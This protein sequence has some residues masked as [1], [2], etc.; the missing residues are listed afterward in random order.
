MRRWIAA[1]VALTGILLTWSVARAGSPTEQLRGFFVATSHILDRE[2][3]EE[4]EER[5]NAIRLMVHDIV[6]FPEVARLSLG[7]NWS[8]RTP[9]ERDEFVPL[10]ADLLE[11]SLIAGIAARIRL[12]DGVKVSYLGESIDG[13]MA[14]VWTTI[15]SRSGLDLPFNYQMIQRRDQWAVRDVMIDGVSVA[16]NYRAQFNRVM[17]LSSYPELVRQ[18]RAKVLRPPMPRFVVTAV[19]DPPMA[20]ILPTLP[21]LEVMRKELA[22]TANR[23]LVAKTSEPPREEVAEG[24]CSTPCRQP[25][26]TIQA[27]P[28]QIERAQSMRSPDRDR[29]LREEPAPPVAAPSPTQSLPDRRTVTAS[30]PPD[31]S[32][33]NARSYWVQIGAFKNPDSAHRLASAFLDQRPPVAARCAVIVETASAGGLV[34]VRVGPFAD[35]SQ[36]ISKFREIQARGYQAFIAEERS[37]RPHPVP[38]VVG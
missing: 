29:P 1:A 17:H 22:E 13:V 36:A 26:N 15:A 35:R 12:P 24:G 18:I 9:A 19:A 30:R 31:G 23:E 2:T 21:A 25:D 37:E 8:V 27:A 16:A 28:V 11:R 6:D 38:C 34:R 33:A 7:P 3:Q 5:F 32:S 14:T 4:P 20:P 10:F